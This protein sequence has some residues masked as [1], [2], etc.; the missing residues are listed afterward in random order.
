MRAPHVSRNRSLWW[1]L[2]AA[3]VVFVAVPTILAVTLSDLALQKVVE[4]EI[5]KSALEKLRVAHSTKTLLEDLVRNTVMRVTLDRDLKELSHFQRYRDIV[6]N[7][8]AQFAFRTYLDKLDNSIQSNPLFHSVYLCLDETDYVLSTVSGVSRRSDFV[9]GPWLEA[10]LTNRWPEPKGTFL[11]PHVPGGQSPEAVVLTYSVPLNPYLTD[12]QGVV[13]INLWER[14][15]SRIINGGQPSGEGTVALVDRS[16]LVVSDTDKSRIG[17]PFSP[18]RSDRHEALLTRHQPEAEGWMYVGTYPLRAMNARIDQIRGWA[19][20]LAFLVVLVGVL[21]SY[22]LARRF[23]HPVRRLI[24]DITRQL[25]KDADLAS[26]ELSLL[27]GAFDVLLK[28]ETQLFQDLEAQRH[29]RVEDW[30]KRALRGDLDRETRPEDLTGSSW[31][32]GTL[33]IDG[34]AGFCQRFPSDQRDYLKSLILHMAE[35]AF[36]PEVR[37]RGA[38][39]DPRTWGL[40]LATDFDDGGA[41]ADRLED[42]FEALG[43]EAR[44]VIG[45][46]LTLCLGGQGS[47]PEVL[48]TSGE[49]A[50]AL[51]NQRFLR[52]HGQWFWHEN[53]DVSDDELFFPPQVERGFVLALEAADRPGLMAALA[54]LDH[55]LKRRKGLGYDNVLLILD[56]LVGALVRYLVERKIDIGLLFGR[57]ANLHRTLSEAETLDEALVWLRSVLNRI[58]D[59]QESAGQTEGYAAAMVRFIR[60]N[61]HRNIGIEEVADHVGISY[62][63]ARKVFEDALGESIAD[64]IQ[65]L[66]IDEARV[67]LVQTG[68]AIDAISDAVGFNS[69]QTFHRAFK[70]VV[71]LTPGE[72][73]HRQS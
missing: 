55:L 61:Y 2:F 38:V 58:A 39:L 24:H 52:G 65:G 13:L 26:D 23:F 27:S 54:A 70:R 40:I 12:V 14:E 72:Y 33:V 56:Q 7:G 32:A 17:L 16:G 5:G 9:D 67:L 18:P 51:V 66:R 19:L 42:G 63:H 57:G 30:V 49:Q 53:P 43:Q 71:G 8:S 73:R 10:A 59:H 62:S 50:E 6:E 45:T 48:L 47:G 28:R 4:D 29:L 15:F 46:S 60:Q 25:G 44:R 69:A 41:L 3:L 34:Y 20:A 64:H 22:V 36:L 35:Q 37:C 31:M 1:K 11:L 21:L 68:D